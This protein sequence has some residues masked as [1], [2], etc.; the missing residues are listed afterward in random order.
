MDR[1][2]LGWRKWSGVDEGENVRPKTPVPMMRIEE[3]GD[4]DDGIV[5]CKQYR[6][7]DAW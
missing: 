1:G 2:E 5:G 4:S 3:G 6:L 7:V